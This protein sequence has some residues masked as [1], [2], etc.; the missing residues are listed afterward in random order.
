MLNRRIGVLVTCSVAAIFGFVIF[1]GAVSGSEGSEG[2]QP[3]A[4]SRPPQATDT[5]LAQLP[6][7][8]QDVRSIAGLKADG[9]NHR[10]Y[11]GKNSKGKTCLI[12]QEGVFGRGGGGCNSSS[13]PFHGRAVMWS[14]VQY[15]ESPQK[16]IVFG[17]VTEKVRGVS[18]TFDGGALTEVP[19]D[20]DGGFIYVVA[21]PAIREID[22]P[23]AINTFDSRG[24]LIEQT[25]LG[26][27][28]GA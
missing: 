15:N 22:V 2:S 13:N 18:L 1:L 19:L 25:E 4:F 12:I 3:R 20:Q 23:T 21:K 28:F 26:I 17:V 5:P 24:R 9:V 14:S 7:L 10:L 16:L 8:A 6:Q 27:A 11:I